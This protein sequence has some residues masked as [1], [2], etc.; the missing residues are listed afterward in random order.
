MVSAEECLIK[1]DNYASAAMI[2]APED[3]RALLR[4]AQIWRNKALRAK[5][6]DRARM[7]ESRPLL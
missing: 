6:G 7:R 1:A 4:L 2:V 5:L 3:A